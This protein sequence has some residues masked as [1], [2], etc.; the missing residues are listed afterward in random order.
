[1]KPQ[2]SQYF[3]W[4]IPLGPLFSPP[5]LSNGNVSF[6]FCL[7]ICI[8]NE[9]RKTI[10]KTKV[11]LRCLCCANSQESHPS[12][13]SSGTAKAILT[14]NCNKYRNNNCCRRWW[15]IR[16]P[17]HTTAVSLSPISIKNHTYIVWLQYWFKKKNLS[18]WK[19][20]SQICE[21][22]YQASTHNRTYSYARQRCFLLDSLDQLLPHRYW[23]NAPCL[24][25]APGIWKQ[26]HVVTRDSRKK[27]LPP[28]QAPKRILPMLNIYLWNRLQDITVL[29]LIMYE[30]S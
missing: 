26:S 18:R 9:N 23:V 4:T 1:M 25:P 14:A 22:W 15:L 29:V 30:S 2:Q 8:Y 17:V 3:K 27:L 19:V 5:L 24:P 7:T 11:I 6:L 13:Q 16:Q 28:A 10:T 21:Q 12:L 20:L